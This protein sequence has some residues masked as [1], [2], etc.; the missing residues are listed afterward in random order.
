[1]IVPSEDE[2]QTVYDAVASVSSLSRIMSSPA[3]FD[4][5][6]DEYRMEREV[7]GAALSELDSAGRLRIMH[8]LP[9]NGHDLP[10][11]EYVYVPEESEGSSLVEP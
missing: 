10:P 8:V 6:E 2:K 11:G 3:L 7:I 1:M 4:V 9:D 5:L